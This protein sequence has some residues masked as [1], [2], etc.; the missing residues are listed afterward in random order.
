MLLLQ[1]WYGLSDYAVEEAVNDR[2]TFSRF[3]G[4]SMDSPVPDHSVLS[5][6]R[7]TLTEK[8]ALESY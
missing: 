6:F 2:I 8:K 7:T 5:R 3:C 4:I 1:T